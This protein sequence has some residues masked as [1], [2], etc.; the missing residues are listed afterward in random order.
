MYPRVAKFL[1]KLI[2]GGT[3]VKI[4]ASLIANQF[5]GGNYMYIPETFA[6]DKHF[7]GLW[8]PSS[9]EAT[10]FQLFPDRAYEINTLLTKHPNLSVRSYCNL[11]LSKTMINSSPTALAHAAAHP[12]SKAKEESDEETTGTCCGGVIPDSFCG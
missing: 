1:H 12:P 5:H 9:K 7:V 8:N 2:N 11:L 6:Y 10:L 3:K 4:S